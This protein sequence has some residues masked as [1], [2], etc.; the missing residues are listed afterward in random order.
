MVVHDSCGGG[1]VL[2]LVA[3]RVVA[4]AAA[5]GSAAERLV[6]SGSVEVVVRCHTRLHRTLSPRLRPPWLEC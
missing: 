1:G 2:M 5:A 3:V 4:S 6:Q